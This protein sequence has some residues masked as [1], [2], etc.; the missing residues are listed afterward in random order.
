[1]AVV[2]PF[3]QDNRSGGD[4]PVCGVFKVL[5]PGIEQQ[6]ERELNLLQRVGEHLDQRCEELQIPQLDYEESFQQA[7]EK[8][9]DE[10]QLEHEQRH[11]VEAKKFFADEPRVQIPELLEHCTSRVTAME[12]LSGGKVTDHALDIAR[13][14]NDDWPG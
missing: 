6:L 12:R 4:E 2:V 10:V 13:G 7:R 1:M 3:R 9:L 11:L 5:K 14:R 8:L